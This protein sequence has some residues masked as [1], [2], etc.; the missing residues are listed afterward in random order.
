[1]P[2]NLSGAY[3]MDGQHILSQEHQAIAEEIAWRYENLRLIW[4]PVTERSVDDI[5]VFAIV[6]RHNRN[7][8]RKFSEIT[9]RDAI[10]WL[11]ENDSQRIDTYAKFEKEKAAA[12]KLATT[13]HDEENNAKL[14]VAAHILASKLHTYKHDGITY[15]DSGV[16]HNAR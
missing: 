5:E 6:D 8:I 16:I 13:I 2:V 4:I 1:M 10:K 15:G 12:E 14:D 7:I 11:W 3:I 9:V